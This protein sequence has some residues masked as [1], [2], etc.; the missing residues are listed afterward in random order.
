MPVRRA[1]CP[2]SSRVD[3]DPNLTVTNL[4]LKHPN[5]LSCY[6]RRGS[7]IFLEPRTIHHS[8]N[9]ANQLQRPVHQEHVAPTS[10]STATR[11][12]TG[13]TAANPPQPL[14]HKLHRLPVPL[15]H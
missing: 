11:R 8:R 6:P 5:A 13:A 2:I 4:F 7:P 3:T 1:R 9:R 12:R 14:I 10:H 15:R